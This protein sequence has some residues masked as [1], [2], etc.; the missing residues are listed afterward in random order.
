[1]QQRKPSKGDIQTQKEKERK[2]STTNTA[3][4][5][6]TEAI[7]LPNEDSSPQ[8]DSTISIIRSPQAEEYLVDP[9][10][11]HYLAFF[12]ATM[13]Y[14]FPYTNLFPSIVQDLFARSVPHVTLRHSL[15]SISSMIADYRQRKSMDRFHFLY[16]CA[17][18]KIQEA[19]STLNVDEG[20]AIAVFLVLWI[21]VVR[22]ELRSSKKH[23]RGL[24]LLLQELQKSY[25]R[26][27]SAPGMLVDQNGGVG[28]TPLI[29]QIWR[30]AIR[31][32]F[33]T[34]LY[35]IDTPVFPVI[36][37]DQQDL[38]RQW[39]R[40]ST[41]SLDAAEWALATFAQDNLMHRACHLAAR[42]RSIRKSPEYT[43]AMEPM[44]IAAAAK[45]QQENEE[46]FTR[47][48]V[49]RAQVLEN[50]AQFECSAPQSPADEELWRFLH[51]PQLRIVNPYYANILNH[52]LT[53]SIYISLIAY[54]EIGPGPACQRYGKAV[55]IC[56]ILAGLGE[57]TSHTASSKIWILFLAGLAFG[58][59]RRAPEETRWA[60]WR[61]NKIAKIFPLMKNAVEIYSGIWEIEGDYWD[62]MD[63][64][65]VK[66]YH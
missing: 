54:P 50:T 35:L 56:R 46:W 26:P 24:Y 65:Q 25:R 29:M 10:D 32:D 2:D 47:P 62:E 1:M 53:T 18:H 34:S 5:E 44:I 4:N 49:H 38:H 19:I 45:L 48:I 11:V 51:Y 40:L 21:D 66:L 12:L 63:M 59:S 60:L 57:D 55:Q 28:V 9:R 43:T 64:L 52:S 7:E 37:S 41:P 27:D 15:L 22:A 20:T 3:S 8:S 39:I 31:L 33:T 61:M 16:I 42:A 14:V 36:P 17:L 23:L 13:P 58:G 6:S 30:I